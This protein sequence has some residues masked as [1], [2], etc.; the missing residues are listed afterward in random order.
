MCYKD[1][2]Q[3]YPDNFLIFLLSDKLEHNYYG[4][5]LINKLFDM[6]ID[7]CLGVTLRRFTDK[8]NQ[9]TCTPLL[10]ETRN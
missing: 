10:Y 7:K 2:F 6:V 3:L 4:T 9:K 8:E 5:A 1:L